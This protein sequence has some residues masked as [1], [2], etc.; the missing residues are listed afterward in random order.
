MFKPL[1]QY[2]KQEVVPR[3]KKVLVT[4]ESAISA[5]VV[6][7]FAKYGTHLFSASPRVSDIVTGVAAYAAIALG[8][9]I[10]GLTISLTLP[11]ETF[12]AKLSETTVGGGNAYS[13]LLFVFSWTAIAHWCAV[14]TMFAIALF[15]DGASPLLPPDSS[16]TRVWL[17]SLAAGL[18]A[19]CLCQFL[20][21]IITLS[22]VGGVYIKFLT[23][24]VKS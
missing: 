24:K 14:V 19:Y 10:A 23:S 13:A 1:A 3:W 6:Y 17:V 20:I 15:S 5:L 11:N 12:A 2:L 8:F 18:L 21:T 22:Q 16:I 7:L 9:C 4:W